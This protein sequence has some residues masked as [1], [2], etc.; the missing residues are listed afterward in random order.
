MRVRFRCD[1]ALRDFLPPPRPA[2]DALPDWLRK[3][4]A[5]AFSDSHCQT[6]RTLKH[7]PPFIDAMTHGFVMSLPC[8]VTVNACELRWDWQIPPLTVE[9]HT[10][11]PVSFHVPTQ[12]K[13][14]PFFDE[15]RA[16]VKFNS[17]WT[18]E[19][20]KGWS[21]MATHPINRL[22]LPFRTLT[23]LVDSDRFHDVGVFFP[24]IWIDPDFAGTLAAGTPIAQCFPVSREELELEL[25]AFSSSEARRYT[26][27]GA[28]I[29]A[30]PGL[31]RKRFRVRKRSGLGE[32][33]A[34]SLEVEDE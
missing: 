4:P 20:E 34:E 10:R 33:V 32:P 6:V 24:A 2:R 11:S 29:K 16:A 17:F 5:M 30:E 9:G 7:C 23:G 26:E 3:M 18:I 25:S 28:A 1:P 8:D 21:L 19:L 12:M 22:D 13:G 15:R 27:T 31:Y 14:T